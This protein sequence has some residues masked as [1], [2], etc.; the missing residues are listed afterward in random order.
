MTLSLRLFALLIAIGSGGLFADE[1]PIIVAAERFEAYI[2]L[3][4]DK[5]LALLVNQTS[6][7][8]DQHLVDALLAQ[9]INITA[10]FAPEHGFR[11]NADAGAH[12][13]DERDMRTGLPVISLYGERKAPNTETLNKIDL[14]LFDIQDVGVRFYTYISSLHYLMQACADTNTPLIVLDRPNPNGDQIDG[15]V[16]DPAFQS[17]VGMHP[18]PLLHGL[19]PGEAALMIN[20]EG[21]L[22]GDQPCELTVI[23]IA[24]YRHDRSYQPPIPPS[25]NLPNYQAIRLYPSLGFFEAAPVSIGRGTPFPFQA[26]GSPYLK[27]EF[28]F[29]PISTPRAAVNPRYQDIQVCGEDYR[30]YPEPRFTLSFLLD[31]RQRL[32]VQGIPLFDRPEWMDKLAGTNKLREQIEAGWDESAIRASWQ[33]ALSQYR[34]MRER[35]RLYD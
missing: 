16:L 6:R 11:G 31:W 4:R 26:A 24:N 1:P 21:W 27:T 7:T 2:P 17:F 29:T 10:V 8:N 32:S 28:C 9:G 18:I 3:L 23:P 20:G 34:A 22:I 35:Y 19:T 5:R 30:K 13:K 25:P 12:I 33:P 15:P 14:L